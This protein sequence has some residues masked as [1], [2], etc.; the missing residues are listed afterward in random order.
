[1][2]WTKR[3][4]PG[5]QHLLDQPDRFSGMARF[6]VSDSPDILRRQSLGTPTARCP[7]PSMAGAIRYP[8]GQVPRAWRGAGAGR[9]SPEQ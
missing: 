2:T 6:Q 9:P 3:P 7:G 5:G 8:C 4:F 1:M